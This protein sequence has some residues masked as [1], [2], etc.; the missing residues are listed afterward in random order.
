MYRTG[1][2]IVKNKLHCN[3]E[4]ISENFSSRCNFMSIIVLYYILNAGI[5]RLATGVCI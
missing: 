4:A 1:F 5:I 2:N 3:T